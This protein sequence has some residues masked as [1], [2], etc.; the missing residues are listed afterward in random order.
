[1]DSKQWAAVGEQWTVNS[2]QRQQ[3]V[4]WAVNS[5]QW[6]VGSGQW[7]EKQCTVKW[8]VNSGHGTVD[9]GLIYKSVGAELVGMT[10]TTASKIE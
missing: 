4:G 9:S 6:T 3:T 8:A 2:G 10:P 5:G 7:A 1:V